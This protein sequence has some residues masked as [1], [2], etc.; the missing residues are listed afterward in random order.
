MPPGRDAD[1]EGRKCF[2]GGLPFDADADDLKHD[3][4]KFGKVEDVH[5]PLD[6][7]TGRPRGFAFVTFFDSLDAEDAAK[8]MH[9]RPYK[10]RDISVRVVVPRSER[11]AGGYTRRSEYDRAGDFDRR[12]RRDDRRDRDYDRRDRDY[13]RRGRDDY[14]DRRDRDYDR[15]DRD[16]DRRDRDYDRRD[17]DY[18]RRRS[19]SR[20]RDRR[21]RRRD[22]DDD[23][24]RDRRRSPSRSRSRSKK[25]EE[26]KEEP[27]KEVEP[28]KED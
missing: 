24:G 9:G 14:Y 3:F 15:R 20:S 12:D 8:D 27:P 21:D 25:E 18:D 4:E 23:Y 1:A 2:L 10:G 26:K 17:R 6:Q 16:Y 7:A 5:L 22:D 13:D 19:P 11:V 28:P